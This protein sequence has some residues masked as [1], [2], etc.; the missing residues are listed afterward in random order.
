MIRN[1]DTST[2]SNKKLIPKYK[3]P[4]IVKKVLDSDRYIITDIEGFQV[5]QLLYNDTVA[6][7]QIK[8]YI[9]K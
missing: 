5:T 4:Y 2:G 7:D 8:P 3:G 1:V 9:P 6:A